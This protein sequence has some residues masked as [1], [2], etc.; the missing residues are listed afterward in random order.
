MWPPT[1]NTMQLSRRALAF[2]AS[3]SR[4]HSTAA[5]FIPRRVLPPAAPHTHTTVPARRRHSTAAAAPAPAPAERALPTPAAAAPSIR[6]ALHLE[7]V[8]RDLFVQHAAALWVPPGGRAVFGGQIVGGAM[9]AGLRTLDGPHAGFQLHSMHSYFLLPGDGAK[10]IVYHVTRLRDG[11]SFCT[12]DV[13]AVQDGRAVF[14]AE[15]SF[16]RS[17]PGGLEHQAAMPE[18]PAPD[19]LASLQQI[20][21]AL[22]NDPRLPP[23]AVALVRRY[24]DAPFPVEIRPCAG[25]D[26]LRSSPVTPARQLVWMRVTEALGDPAA[27]RD[28]HRSAVAFASDWSLA[29][30]MLLPHGLHYAHPSIAMIASLDHVLHFAA[31]V[32]FAADDWLLYEMESPLLRGARGVNLGR[33]YTRDGR[34]IVCCLQEALVRMRGGAGGGQKA[35]PPQWGM[36]GEH[37]KRYRGGVGGAD[38]GPGSATAT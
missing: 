37:A 4:P 22:L 13:K 19:G 33:I 38:G 35:A 3:H 2:A 12:R 21:A 34:L 31:D 32:V 6:R 15:L 11:G 17:E 18:A 5:T 29:S 7:Q 8:D 1:P 36:A 16:H 14:G 30:T 23:P 9:A 28:L 25:W 20:Y 24:V 26:P 10:N 27:S